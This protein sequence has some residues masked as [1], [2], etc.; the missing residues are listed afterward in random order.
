MVYRVE[1]FKVFQI[2]GE[3]EGGGWAFGNRTNNLWILSFPRF[4]LDR[5]IRKVL[6]WIE[7]PQG[8]QYHIPVFWNPVAGSESHLVV[9]SMLYYRNGGERYFLA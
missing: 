1:F 5:R 9:E 8:K 2:L 6:A 3:R 4:A 7:T